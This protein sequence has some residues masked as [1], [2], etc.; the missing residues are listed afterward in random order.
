MRE[1]EIVYNLIIYHTSSKS[2]KYDL[3]YYF[4]FKSFKYISLAIVHNYFN[5]L[6]HNLWYTYTC[7][8]T[9][10]FGR[11]LR[12]RVPSSSTRNFTVS[13]RKAKPY[14]NLIGR[15]SNVMLRFVRERAR[16]F[17]EIDHLRTGLPKSRSWTS[18]RIFF[19]PT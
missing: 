17:Y 8:C 9:R 1:K 14:R 19:P 15:G 3:K 7:T 6:Y 18:Q 16:S 5:I 2:Y 4:T 10:D 11:V 13:L 12:S